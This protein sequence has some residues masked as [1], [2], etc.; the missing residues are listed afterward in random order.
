VLAPGAT[1]YLDTNALIYITE[2]RAPFRARIQAVLSEAV[3]ARA[4]LVTSELAITEVLVLPLRD[5]DNALIRAERFLCEPRSYAQR[6]PGCV[7]RTLFTWLPLSN[8]VPPC[9]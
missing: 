1:V 8:W 9:S 4:T 5:R 7:R 3:T 6:P 2:G